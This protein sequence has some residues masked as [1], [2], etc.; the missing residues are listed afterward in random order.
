[1]GFYAPAQL[2]RDA[3]AHGVEVRAVDVCDQRGRGDARSRGAGGSPRAK[4]VTRRRG[5]RCAGAPGAEPGRRPRRRRGAAHRRRARARRRSPARKTWRAAPRS[6][7]TSCSRWRRPARCGA[8]SG[9]RAATAIRPRG[10]WPASTP[11]R[12]RCCT[13][14]ASPRH[15]RSSPRPSEAE[16]MV[17]DYRALGLSLARH[18]LALLR[19][20]TGRVSRP[21]R[22]GAATATR[23]GGSRAPAAWSRTASGPRRPRAR[24]SS[25]S[26]TRPAP[27]T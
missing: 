4:T 15:R 19:E 18:P 5:A 3:R 16:D 11:G 14:R 24:C 8:C 10:R 6:T 1:M 26:K 25:R 20:R 7:R 17:A 2:V 23:T 13:P 12:P 9:L 27:S 22:G 21:A